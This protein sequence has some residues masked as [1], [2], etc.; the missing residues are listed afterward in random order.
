MPPV[1]GKTTSRK[2]DFFKRDENV[3][4]FFSWHDKTKIGTILRVALILFSLFIAILAALG[5]F[6]GFK[7]SSINS[8]SPF[9]R[10]VPIVI[11]FALAVVGLFKRMRSTFTRLLT[12]LLAGIVVLLG[13]SVI[14]TYTNAI[15]ILSLSEYGTTAFYKYRGEQGVD[16]DEKQNIVILYCYELPDGS[17]IRNVGRGA[18][19][20][21]CPSRQEVYKVSLE[22]PDGEDFTATGAIYVKSDEIDK[23]KIEW[24]DDNNARIYLTEDATTFIPEEMIGKAGVAGESMTYRYVFSDTSFMQDYD[25]SSKGVGEPILGCTDTARAGNTIRLRYEKAY[26]YQALSVYRMSSD[27]FKMHFIAYPSYLFNLFT[28]ADIKTEGMIT[29]EP[30]GSIEKFDV[31]YNKNENVVRVKPAEGSLGASGEIVLY[32]NEKAEQSEASDPEKPVE[33][34]ITNGK[35]AFNEIIVHFQ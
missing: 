5:Y 23:L 9:I 24:T 8:F 7:L 15:P 16:G 32:L 3:L 19:E 14:S 25:A 28:K 22:K 29:M 17:Y 31:E 1:K 12:G 26:A 27:G 20:A 11:V 21:V 33:P 13:I 18:T 4:P 6:A 10:I 34:D 2:N 30:Y 35:P